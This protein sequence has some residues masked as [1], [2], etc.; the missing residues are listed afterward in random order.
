MYDLYY[1]VFQN[2]YGEENVKLLFADTDS[3]FLEITTNDLYRN[4]YDDHEFKKHFDFSDYPTYLYEEIKPEK[5]MCDSD[6]YIENREPILY[7]NQFMHSNDNK[8]VI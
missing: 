7:Y 5:Y 1:N 2:K 6:E 4:I 8:K 3:L